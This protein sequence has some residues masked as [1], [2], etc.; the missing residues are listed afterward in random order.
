[1]KKVVKKGY[2]GNEN[3]GL[4]WDHMKVS[5]MTLFYTTLVVPAFSHG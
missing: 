2:C 3:L 1:M 5:L 4:T